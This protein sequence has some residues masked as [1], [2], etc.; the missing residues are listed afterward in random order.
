M[1][2]TSQLIIQH[3]PPSSTLKMEAA[4]WSEMLVYTHKTTWHK[5]PEDN[6]IHMLNIVA[7]WLICLLN[8]WKVL[9]SNLSPETGY[10]DGGFHVFPHSLQTNTLNYAMNTSFHILSNSS[11]TCHPFIQCYNLELLRKCH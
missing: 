1:D 11:F 8:I 3:I 10:P 2:Y 9:G 4:W 6:L 5:N 7:E